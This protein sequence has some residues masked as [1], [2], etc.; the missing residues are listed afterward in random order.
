MLL[1]YIYINLYFINT[2]LLTP[3]LFIKWIYL[4]KNYKD[5]LIKTRWNK[6][7]FLIKL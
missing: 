3:D 6:Q 7:L 5:K 4:S 2:D 1:L